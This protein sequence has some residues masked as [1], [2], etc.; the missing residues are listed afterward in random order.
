MC[1]R[2]RLDGGILLNLSRLNHIL[3]LQSNNQ[4]AVVEAC[5]L[6]GELDKEACKV[7]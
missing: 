3:S 5:V 6:N 7:G 1:I 4:T 2:C